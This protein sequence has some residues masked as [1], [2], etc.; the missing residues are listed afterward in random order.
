MITV[1]LLDLIFAFAALGCAAIFRTR[2][3]D[4]L[5]LLCSGIVILLFLTGLADLLSTG[6]ILVNLAAAAM[7]TAGVITMCRRRSF[8][9]VSSLV[10]TPPF[11]VFLLLTL[12]FGYMYQ[13]IQAIHWD[14]FSYWI[15]VV[16]VMTDKDAFGTTPSYDVVIPSY[17]PGMALFQYYG[18]ELATRLR[19]DDGFPEWVCYY[20]YQVLSLSFFLP[21]LGNAVKQKRADEPRKAVF[22][23]LAKIIAITFFYMIAPM[24]YFETA[25]V[26]C[27]IDPFVAMLAGMGF[28]RIITEHQKGLCYQLSIL[29][30]CMMLV[31]AKSIGMLYAAFI[32]T[33]FMTDMI[34]FHRPERGA[35]K[36]TWSIF[37][38]SSLMPM[39]GSILC[40]LLWKWELHAKHTQLLFHHHIDYLHYIRIF[41]AGGDP[42]YRQQVA[43]NYK[44]ALLYDIHLPF[45][46]SYLLELVI[47]TVTTVLLLF[48]LR[49]RKVK[50]AQCA[51]VSGLCLLCTVLYVFLLGAVYMYN[52]SEYEAV[53]LASIDRYLSISFLTLAIVLVTMAMML[54]ET[55]SHPLKWV[56][57]AAAMFY[58][59]LSITS[60]FSLLLKGEYVTDTQQ[61]RKPYDTFADKMQEFC[62]PDDKILFISQGDLGYDYYVLHFAA[63]PLLISQDPSWSLV[64]ES[65]DQNITA[66]KITPEEWR[67]KVQDYAYI[68]IYKT[69]ELFMEQYAVIF[70]NPEVISDY[71]FY[72]IHHDSM[73]LEQLF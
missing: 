48:L 72:R 51:V 70:N 9:Q 61:R 20:C 8:K 35:S 34:C 5:P 68:V 66:A 29:A 62:T 49:R 60:Y 42:T 43:D 28:V 41:F 22:A 45:G 40:K 24:L 10:L 46:V 47:L 13:G 56:V 14:E 57:L 27:Y 16:K 59:S 67:L 53:H 1:L 63:R 12:S 25:Y 31:L 39:T 2:F 54:W 33:A 26:S 52:F 44:H 19:P 4:S 38:I 32:A 23:S 30:Q 21:L 11:F 58:F 69:D 73:R 55:F 15:D 71:S 7:G 18:A 37:F 65:S 6:V 64:N 50:I 3:E 17:L 36:T